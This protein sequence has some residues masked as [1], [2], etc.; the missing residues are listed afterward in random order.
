MR[1]ALIVLALA[2]SLF[3]QSEI[4]FQQTVP[5]DSRTMALV[6]EDLLHL[7]THEG[8]RYYVADTA[9]LGSGDSL[10]YTF[11][12]PTSGK[13]PHIVFSFSSSGA[14]TACLYEGVVSP[15]PID[16]LQNRNHNRY[17]S[18]TTGQVVVSTAQTAASLGS[19]L[20]PIK[21]GGVGVGTGAINFTL[22]PGRD[23]YILR[24]G[25]V[26]AVKIKS[27]A[28]SNVIRFEADWYLKDL[29]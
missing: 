21:S 28:S 18:D 16:T 11:A 1:I 14:V 20:Y 15:T 3:S 2:A 24:K 23:E 17:G 25:T 9:T 6:V 8:N 7:E 10:I 19:C 22:D 5:Y 29:Q 4:K 27:G 12:A 26:Y 13:T